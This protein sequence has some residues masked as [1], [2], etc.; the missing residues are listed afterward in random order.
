MS[1]QLFASIPID[2]DRGS[3]PGPSHL[4]DSTISGVPTTTIGPPTTGS[5]VLNELWK[6]ALGGVFKSTVAGRRGT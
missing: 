1:M 4:A 3:I 5:R 6:D 2:R